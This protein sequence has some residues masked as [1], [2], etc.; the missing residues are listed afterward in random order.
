MVKMWKGDFFRR[1]CLF[2]WV[3]S[4]HTAFLTPLLLRTE[5]SPL[6]TTFFWLFCFA[7]YQNIKR[8]KGS[9]SWKG[10][11]TE[12]DDPRV[13][14]SL[15]KVH[16]KYMSGYLDRNSVSFENYV[17]SGLQTSYLQPKWKFRL[18]FRWTTQAVRAAPNYGTD[19][20]WI[21]TRVLRS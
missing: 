18:S 17:S 7:S 3:W 2:L 12:S 20:V 9:I 19:S 5:P 8:L 21:Q 16:I 4:R 10:R 6:L 11:S 13:F 1:G 15:P 14:F